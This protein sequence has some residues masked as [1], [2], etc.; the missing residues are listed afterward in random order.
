MDSTTRT[1][2]LGSTARAEELSLDERAALI[3]ESVDHAAHYLPAQGPI[4]VFI[5]HNTLHAFEEEPFE[6]AV[7]RAARLFGTEPFLSESCYREELARGR[8]RVGDIEAV[9]A[10][11]AD[12]EIRVDQRI[13]A[14]CGAF[15]SRTVALINRGVPGF[16]VERDGTLHSSLMR[17][18]TG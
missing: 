12:A 2:T 15:E 6:E 3:Q 1:G 9:V 14:D 8:I 16:A 11:L 17:S 10:D 18:C 4:D 5:H 7:V 13:A